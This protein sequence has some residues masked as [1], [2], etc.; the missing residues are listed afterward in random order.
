MAPETDT[1]PLA[2]LDSVE[3]QRRQAGLRLISHFGPALAGS[4]MEYFSLF[5]A[6]LSADFISLAMQMKH[7]Q[8]KGDL[9]MLGKLKSIVKTKG[10]II[11]LQA[12]KKTLIKLFFDRMEHDYAGKKVF[13]MASATDLLDTA[14]Q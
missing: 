4:H 10:E 13:L 14:V 11:T 6:P 7:A 9:T 12:R 2:W 5:N 8:D 3:H 1:S